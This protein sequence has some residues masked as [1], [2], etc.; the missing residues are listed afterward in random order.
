MKKKILLPILAFAVL[1][2]A[3]AVIFSNTKSK[4]KAY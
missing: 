2:T 4:N 3:I 1:L